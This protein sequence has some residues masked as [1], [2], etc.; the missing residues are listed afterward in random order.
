LWISRISATFLRRRTL[1]AWRGHEGPGRLSISRSDPIRCQ[2]G[3]S[4]RPTR[5]YIPVSNVPAIVGMVD[6]FCL[7]MACLLR[8]RTSSNNCRRR[9]AEDVIYWRCHGFDRLSP[10]PHRFYS[11]PDLRVSLELLAMSYIIVVQDIPTKNS[12]SR[13]DDY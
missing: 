11:L 4:T 12:E 5:I 7:K 8:A 2:E 13:F 9:E 1:H 3:G 10:S 6:R